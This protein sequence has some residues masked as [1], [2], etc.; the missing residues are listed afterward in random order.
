MAQGGK[1]NTNHSRAGMHYLP[2]VPCIVVKSYEEP[3]NGPYT[4]EDWQL[5]DLV[6]FW[7]SGLAIGLVIGLIVTGN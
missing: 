7:L 5:V 6:L 1:V 4:R 3:I 2:E